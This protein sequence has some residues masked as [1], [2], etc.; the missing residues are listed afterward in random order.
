[1]T[2]GIAA[3]ALTNS[4]DGN[5]ILGSA[6]TFNVA[7]DLTNDGVINIGANTATVGGNVNG[8]GTVSLDVDFSTGAGGTFVVTGDLTG[9]LVV[10]VNNLGAEPTAAGVAAVNFLQVNG[11]ITGSVRLADG[12]INLGIYTFDLNVADGQ[13]V[14]ASVVN[15]VGAV[16]SAHSGV[17]AQGFASFGSL[18]SRA[19][20][21]TYGT[22]RQSSST[23]T[24][25]SKG[26][27]PFGGTVSVGP[28][29]SIE[30]ERSTRSPDSGDVVRSTNWAFE[31][32]YDSV[33]DTSSEGTWIVGAGVRFGTV[34][35][36]V[37]NALGTSALDSEGKGVMLSASHYALTGSYLDF[38]LRHSMI[39]AEMH[40]QNGGLLAK[41]VKSKATV[42]SIEVGHR[43]ALTQR[44]SLTPNAQ[45]VFGRTETKGYTDAN[46]LAVA[47]QTTDIRQF[48][49][50]AQFDHALKGGA[51]L[52]LFGDYL[53]DL[54][55]T[56]TI[57][58]NGNVLTSTSPRDWANVGLR[59]NAPLGA[60]SAV[61]GEVGYQTAV[62]AASSN[63]ES[64]F[65]RLGF[66]LRF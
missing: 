31:G 32:G 33:L 25:S 4:G 3:G 55:A 22:S 38:S 19:A 26:S 61:S 52:G 13:I 53:R 60:S 5:I 11:A 44:S 6:S 56:S 20:S 2:G 28:W 47:A 66:D 1:V 43:L 15:P 24:V 45:M 50:G 34:S 57:E 54:A 12:P 17:V 21:R 9:D 27:G 59:L 18:G 65:A 10:S 62:G 51:T 14:A 63:N 42:A 8:S 49:F 23:I 48:R 46:G 41:D 58:V 36:T 40:D 37:E 35:A 30:G 16:Y 29:A 39:S 7:G 64:A